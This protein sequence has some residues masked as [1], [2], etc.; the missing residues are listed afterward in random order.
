MEDMRKRLAMLMDSRQWR[1]RYFKMVKAALQHPD[2]QTFLKQHEAELA[3]DAID[4][5]T[6]KIYEFVSERNK[7]ARGEL[8]LAPGYQPTLV[9]ANGLIDV[10]YEPTDAK[11][12]ADEEAKQAS[13]VTSVNMP[14]DIHDASLTSYDPTDERVDALLA[15]NR[16]VLAVVADPKTFHQGLYLNGPFG[17]G[18]TYLLGAIAND[19]ASKG[20]IATT[21]IH[22][23]TFVVEM[24]SA[25]GS[26]TVLKKI[27]SVKRAQVLMLDDIG[28]ESISPWVRD[29]VLGI[30][31][32]YRMQE[33]MPTLF[34]SNKSMADLTESLAGTDRGNSE[35]L[36]AQRIMERIRFLAKEVTVGGE[37][38]RNPLAN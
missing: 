31:L 3:D 36:K 17:V 29:D 13:L 26:N 21:L 9:V 10:A 30:I 24:K 16:F 15:A 38:R 37:N 6:A 14:K 7:I 5:G 2:V 20:G 11:L 8:P 12:A 19:L 32:Q 34:S 28:A 1:E 18:K 22:V 33:K 4:R 35:M 27:D 23:P 25:I